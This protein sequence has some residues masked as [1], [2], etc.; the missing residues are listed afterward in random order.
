MRDDNA[1]RIRGRPEIDRGRAGRSAGPVGLSC[2]PLG[3]RKTPLGQQFYVLAVLRQPEENVTP[4]EKSEVDRVISCY[5]E[6]RARRPELAQAEIILNVANELRWAKRV[7]DENRFYRETV[8]ARPRSARSPVRS[9][10]A[11]Q[12]RRRR[13]S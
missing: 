11:A 9:M 4:L 8:T 10:L 2:T 12:A 6:L 13:W 1:G 7:D 5:R 3:G